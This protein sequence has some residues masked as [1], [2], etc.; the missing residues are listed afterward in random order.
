MILSISVGVVRK[1]K[2][3]RAASLVALSGVVGPWL[4]RRVVRV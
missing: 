1:W 3:E 4:V 2:N